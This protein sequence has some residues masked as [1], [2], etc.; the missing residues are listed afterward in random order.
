MTSTYLAIDTILAILKETP[1]RLGQLTSGLP[2]AQLQAAPGVGEWSAAEVLAHLR[3]C[4][5]VWG[6]YYI[7]TILREEDPTIKAMN[8]RTWIKKTNYLEQDFHASLRAF[9]KQRRKLLAVLE[10]LP[11]RDW[12]RTNTLIGA[13]KPLRQ[14]LISH[15]DGLARHERAHLKQIE[16]LLKALQA[17]P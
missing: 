10:P 17:S 8:P 14:T 4:N 2:P 16:R 12:T 7:M 9:R 13:G 15:A 6:N 11:A 1:S 5:E 3:A